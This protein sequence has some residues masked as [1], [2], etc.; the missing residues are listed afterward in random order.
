[1]PSGTNSDTCQIYRTLG[2]TWNRG[3]FVYPPPCRPRVVARQRAASLRRRDIPAIRRNSMPSI[4]E[5]SLYI[6]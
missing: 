6:N 1:M 3:A 2:L 5:K 4:F